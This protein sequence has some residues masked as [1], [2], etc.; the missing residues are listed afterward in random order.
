MSVRKAGTWVLKRLRNTSDH[1]TATRQRLVTAEAYLANLKK[2]DPV[3]FENLKRQ[4]NTYK[5]KL[6]ECHFRVMTRSR[7]KTL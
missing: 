1:Y 2:R 7:L 3:L 6:E 5:Q 4:I